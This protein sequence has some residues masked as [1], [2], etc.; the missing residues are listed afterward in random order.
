[1]SV[2]GFDTTV[3]GGGGNTPDEAVTAAIGSGQLAS[4]HAVIYNATSGDAGGHTY[5]VVDA[6]GVAGYQS[7]QDFLFDLIAGTNLNSL[8]TGDFILG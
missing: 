4:H 8:G 7:G 3:T 1:M 2:T 6:N 5:L